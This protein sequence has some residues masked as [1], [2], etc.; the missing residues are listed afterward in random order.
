[1]YKKYRY[2]SVLS[3]RV[4]PA[5][6]LTAILILAACRKNANEWSQPD[7]QIGFFNASE[8]LQNQMLNTHGRSYIL[9]DTKDTTHSGST[10]SVTPFFG[11]GENLF[12]FPNFFYYSL[13]PLPWISYMRMHPGTHTITLTDTGGVHPLIT[14]GVTTAPGNPVTVYFAD[15]LGY[16]RSWALTDAVKEMP[17]MVMLR[18]LHLSPDAGNVFFTIGG[19]AVTGFPASMQY[20]QITSFVARPNPVADTLQIRFYK[21]GDSVN[22]LTSASLSVLPGH[23]YNLVLRGY[24]NNRSFKDP[25]TGKYL[26]FYPDLKV[27]LTQN[28]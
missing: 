26:N 19:Q 18:A 17:G 23:A 15:S 6:L 1:M 8:Y 21:A 16:F 20:G 7:S 14:T 3:T 5:G 22:V 4:L 11:N 28:D 10:A 27:M 25:I 9:I 2:R 13:Q 12:Q 24:L